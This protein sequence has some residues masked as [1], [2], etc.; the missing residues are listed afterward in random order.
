MESKKLLGVVMVR[1]KKGETDTEEKSR[2]IKREKKRE[3]QKCQRKYIREDDNKR[4]GPS[5]SITQNNLRFTSVTK[6]VKPF[7][8]PDSL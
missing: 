1:V 2:P 4:K 3:F 5:R 8:I 6:T 7:T